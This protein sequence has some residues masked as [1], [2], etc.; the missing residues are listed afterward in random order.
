[1]LQPATYQTANASKM[2]IAVDKGRAVWTPQRGVL[3]VSHATN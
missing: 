2:P 1:M 3:F